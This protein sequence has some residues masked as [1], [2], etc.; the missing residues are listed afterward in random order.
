MEKKARR[1]RLP[2]V[3][4]VE[5]VASAT[6]RETVQEKLTRLMLGDA[7]RRIKETANP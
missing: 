1:G 3:Y 7:A 6:A 2:E 5:N 4:I